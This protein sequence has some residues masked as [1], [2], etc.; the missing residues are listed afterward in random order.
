M[1]LWSAIGDAGILSTVCVVR[2]IPRQSAKIRDVPTPTLQLEGGRLF[3]LAIHSIGSV[4]GTMGIGDKF[5]HRNSS[6][7]LS[8]RV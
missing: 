6:G 8:I 7:L 5:S 4:L 2:K 3:Q 1:W